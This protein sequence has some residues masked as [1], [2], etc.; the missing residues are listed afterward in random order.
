MAKNITIKGARVNNLK[1]ISQ[2][3]AKHYLLS[4]IQNSDIEFK[5]YLILNK[6]ILKTRLELFAC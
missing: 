2:D 6:I 1:N 4:K 5:M 3:E